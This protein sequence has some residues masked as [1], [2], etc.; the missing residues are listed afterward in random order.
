VLILCYFLTTEE[1]A[2]VKT[3]LVSTIFLFTLVPIKVK[4]SLTIGKNLEQTRQSITPLHQ[5]VNNLKVKL[6]RCT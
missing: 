6:Q 5:T 3:L 1:V 2:L 4:I